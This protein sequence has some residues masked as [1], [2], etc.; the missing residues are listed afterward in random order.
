VETR[1]RRL[2]AFEDELKGEAF[3]KAQEVQALQRR[4]R[5]DAKHQVELERM[6]GKE[7]EE[8]L[9]RYAVHPSLDRCLDRFI[10]TSQAW[11]A[12]VWLCVRAG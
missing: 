10:G 11:R 5:E 4:L 2:S 3:K 7:L 6:R 8:R 9:A 1:E 12:C